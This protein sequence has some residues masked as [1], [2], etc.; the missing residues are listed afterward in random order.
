[1]A[2]VEIRVGQDGLAG[3]VVESDV[4]RREFGGRGDDQGMTYPL[5]VADR[6]AQRLHAAQAAADDGCPL[7]DAESICESGLCFHPVTDGDDGE[8]GPPGL[9]RCRVGG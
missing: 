4:L 6:P 9:T 3:N 5:R 1:M 8:V 2:A 7:I